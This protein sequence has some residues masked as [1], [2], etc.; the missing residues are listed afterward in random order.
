[1]YR[2]TRTHG[3]TR[4][5]CSVCTRMPTHQGSP[6][7]TDRPGCSPANFRAHNRFPSEA[8]PGRCSGGGMNT[9][10]AD[11]GL[12][13]PQLAPSPRVDRGCF[14]P[15]GA[16]C[17]STEA[18]PGGTAAQ[19]GRELE[20]GGRAL[21]SQPSTKP[22]PAVPVAPRRAPLLPSAPSSAGCLSPQLGHPLLTSSQSAAEHGWSWL[23]W[24]EGRPS[25]AMPR[26]GS[27]VGRG[28]VQG[29]RS[30]LA[31]AGSGKGWPGHWV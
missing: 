11:S 26:A 16:S 12:D 7:V 27:S 9:Q 28:G 3:T 18:K 22:D 4:V 5:L 2:R 20:A 30:P 13:R 10:R 31:R 14:L 15:C 23:C 8:R 17:L 29:T 6:G 21:T 24:R 25:L 1:M 19:A